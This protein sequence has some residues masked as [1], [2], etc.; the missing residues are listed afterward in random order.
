MRR[1]PPASVV[2]PALQ[3]GRSRKARQP[4]PAALGCGQMY[5]GIKLLF[6]RRDGRRGCTRLTDHDRDRGRSSGRARRVALAAGGG[7]RIR[8]APVARN[9]AKGEEP[10]STS[11]TRTAVSSSSS[12]TS[13]KTI[14][15]RDR[16]TSRPVSRSAAFVGAG[17]K[18][19]PLRRLRFDPRDGGGGVRGDREPGLVRVDRGQEE[20]CLTWSGGRSCGGSTSFGV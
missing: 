13:H 3:G 8:G 11:A 18:L 5:C 15:D 14:A 17:E 7:G 2:P 1:A 10:A 6:S 19:T 16:S 20:A 12:P 4:G 9:G